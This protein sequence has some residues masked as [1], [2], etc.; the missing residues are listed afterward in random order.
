MMNQRMDS[1]FILRHSAFAFR[2]SDAILEQCHMEACMT[3]QQ[4]NESG[5]GVPAL[6]PPPRNVTPRARRRAWAEPR[7]RFWWLA[8]AALL[9]VAG[10]FAITQGSRWAEQSRLVRQGEHVTAT[11]VEVEGI[12]RQGFRSPTPADVVVEFTLGEATHRVPGRIEPQEAEAVMT[13]QTLAVSVDRRDPSRWV[14]RTV[15]PALGRELLAVWLLLPPGILLALGAWL[16]WR[17]VLATWRDGQPLAALV[18]DVGQSAVAPLSRA[19][20]CTPRDGR[21]SRILT[22]Y[23]PQRHAAGLQP[24]DP[25]WLIA[26]PAQLHKAIPATPYEGSG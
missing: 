24:G 12:A 26:P 15:A 6:S 22:V 19:V 5:A 13:Q 18:V 4:S 7:V 21:D 23:L 8:S 25:L 20:R 11:I 2:R 14:A 9:L 17:S 1:A 10:Y 16:A 3:Q